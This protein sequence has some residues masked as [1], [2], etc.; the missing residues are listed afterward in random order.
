[1]TPGNHET[2]D[3][4]S[5]LTFRF[6]DPLFN[7]SQNHYLSF[8]WQGIHF[9]LLDYDFYDASS[10]DVQDTI[11]GWIE[12]DLQIANDDKHRSVW[13]WIVVVSHRPI[14]CTSSPS[15]IPEDLRC[16]SFYSDKQIW[17]ELFFQYHVDLVIQGHIHN[18]E[19]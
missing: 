5:F 18:Y 11:Y 6:R 19:R 13:P 12:N 8:N 15:T 1:M 16:Y 4:Y 9:V 10:P 2:Y 7:V 14:Y 17:D 3:N